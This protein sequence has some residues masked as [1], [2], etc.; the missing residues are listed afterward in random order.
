M[1]KPCVGKFETPFHIRLNNHRKDIKDPS[2]MSACKHF[3]LPNHDFITSSP[4][5]ILKDLNK[6]ETFGLKNKTHH[7]I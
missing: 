6:E 7:V 2:A 3:N 4:T 5:E 1:Q